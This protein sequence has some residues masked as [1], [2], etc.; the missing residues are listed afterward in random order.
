MAVFEELVVCL[1]EDGEAE[2]YFL[3]IFVI[4]WFFKLLYI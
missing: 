3:L 4:I 2:F 1:G